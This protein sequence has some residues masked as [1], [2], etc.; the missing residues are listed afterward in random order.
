MYRRPG[1]YAITTAE[2]IFNETTLQ[3]KTSNSRSSEFPNQRVVV[4]PEI[5][6]NEVYTYGSVNKT[7]H[8]HF[9][10]QFHTHQ[11]FYFHPVTT[12]DYHT[13]PYSA[14]Q[15]HNLHQDW[16][17]VTNSSSPSTVAT[18]STAVTVSCIIPTR[19]PDINSLV[20]AAYVKTETNLDDHDCFLNKDSMN[21]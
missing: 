7:N 19:Y 12:H 16:R 11:P 10:Q 3:A 8:D 21:N 14:Q 15:L 6:D 5:L 17:E 18:P 4:R 20:P 13:N 9:H 2:S 1:A